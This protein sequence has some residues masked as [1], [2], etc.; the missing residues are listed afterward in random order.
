RRCRT[1]RTS[2]TPRSARTR[3]SGPARSPRTSGTKRAG[4]RAAPR[5]A[6]TSGRESTMASSPPWKSE[7]EHGSQL[8][9]L[10]RR[11]YRPMLLRLREPDRRTGRGMQPGTGTTELFLPGLDTVPAVEVAPNVTDPAPVH[12][13]ERGPQKRLMV[14]SGR[15]HEE[16]A[17]RITEQLGIQ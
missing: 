17:L 12:W 5:S 11:T 13:I 6:R 16:L 14:V 8:V 3:T 15:S 2:A 4:P 9:R 1:S 7:T 10:S